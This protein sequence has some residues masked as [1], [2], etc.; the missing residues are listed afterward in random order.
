MC[1]WMQDS[2]T[3]LLLHV[4]DDIM[5][6][7]PYSQRTKL[8]YKLNRKLCGAHCLS[9]CFGYE[10]SLV[11]DSNIATIVY[12][13]ARNIVTTLTALTWLRCA[14]LAA[15]KNPLQGLMWGD[16]KLQI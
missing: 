7:P 15:E 1:S 6:P 3:E 12:R 4:Q 11:S 8:L 9:G 5:P 10:K 16:T 14:V 2:V 13:P